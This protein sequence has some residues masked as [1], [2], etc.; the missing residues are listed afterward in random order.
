MGQDDFF[1]IGNQLY[2]EYAL[3]NTFAKPEMLSTLLQV[4]FLKAER[5]KEIHAKSN[6]NTYWLETFNKFKN[7]LEKDYINSRSSK[8]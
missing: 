2:Y 1:N 7:L 8:F 4:L 5:A 3:A 6:I